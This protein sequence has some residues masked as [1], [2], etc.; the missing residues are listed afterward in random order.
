MVADG[1][2]KYVSFKD[3]HDLHSALMGM[4]AMFACKLFG[5]ILLMQ[6][7]AVGMTVAG[8]AETS[9]RTI[10]HPDTELVTEGPAHLAHGKH[11]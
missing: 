3:N 4:V 8:V 10:G 11:E 6:G 1:T 9:F 5:G 2:T 7:F